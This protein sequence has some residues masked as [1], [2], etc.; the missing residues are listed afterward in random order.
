MHPVPSLS[1]RFDPVAATPQVDNSAP[2]QLSEL[3]ILADTPQI[4]NP[5]L[6]SA[7]GNLHAGDLFERQI[8][9]LYL[10]RDRDD[11]WIKSDASDRCDAKLVH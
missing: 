5:H 8:D 7:D 3:T 10:F 6:L 11:D 9:G 1:C 4:P 2:T